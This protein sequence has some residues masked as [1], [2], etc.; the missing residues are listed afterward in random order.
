[1]VVLGVLF[2]GL[3]FVTGDDF[4]DFIEK[5]NSLIVLEGPVPGSIEEDLPDNLEPE[6]ANMYAFEGGITGTAKDTADDF[7]EAN[8]R[9]FKPDKFEIPTGA[10]PSP[11]FGARPFSQKLLRLEEFGNR[12]LPDPSD[13]VAGDSFPP[14]LDA[15]S[16]PDS[17]SLDNFLDQGLYPFPQREANVADFNPWQPEIEEFLDRPLDDPPV[18]GRPP[19]PDWSHQRWAEFYPEVYVKTAQRGARTNRGYRDSGQLH[20][21]SLGEFAPGG[22][23]HNTLGNAVSDPDFEGTTRGI[24]VKFHPNMPEQHPNSLWT[25]DGTF[26]PK[27]LMVR[28]GEPILFRHYNALPIDPAANM[29]F[30]LHTITT[31]EHNGH[32]PAESDGFIQAFFFPGQFYDYRWPLC[33]AGHDSINVDA[34]DDRAGAPDGNG[35]INRIPG[36]YRETMSTH[37]FHDHMM[38]FTAPNVYKG[39][40]AAMNYYSSLDRGN[41]GLEDGV[42]LRLPSGTAL[43]WGNRDYDVN[44]L[45]SDKAWDSDGQLFF[46]IFNMDGFLGDR[47]LTNWLWNPYFDV[48]ARRYRFRLLNGA[49]ARYF[50]LALVREYNGSG[51]R[52]RGPSGSRKT[53]DRVPFHMIANDG[54][55]MEHSVLFS[56]GLTPTLSIGERYDIIV[57]FSQFEPGTKLHLVNVLEHRNGKRPHEVVFLGEVLSGEYRI[58]QWPNE[59]RKG[60]PAVGKI[61][62]FRVH[63]YTGTDLSMDPAD[64][65]SVLPDGQKGRK[66]IPL[67]TFTE[68]E[69]DNA[70]HRT[71]EFGK[72]SGT[73]SDPWTIKTDGGRGLLSDPR[74]VSAAPSLGG[75]EIWHLKNGGGGWS[76][77]IHVHFEEGVILERG[78]EPP[79]EWEKWARKDMFRVGRMGDSGDSVVVAFRFR[80]FL[81]TYMEHCH[82]TQ[83]EDHAMLLRFDSENPGQ[84]RVMPTPMPTWDGVGYV[85]SFA[86]PT[87]RAGDLEATGEHVFV[88]G[89]VNNDLTLDVADPV[90]LLLFLFQLGEAPKCLAAADCNDDELIDIVDP[91]FEL[92]ALF[93]GGSSIPAPWPD[94]GFDPTP[95]IGCDLSVAQNPNDNAGLGD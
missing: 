53:Y 38:D 14:P 68:E 52:M 75:V 47:V 58:D 45:I 57:D 22:L 30:G 51:G 85:P 46:N 89:N 3:P 12:E 56:N 74:R 60:D 40:I 91:V 16:G 28:V 71:F 65:V 6:E 15:Q 62:E 7:N 13:V 63:E 92:L 20:E 61:M 66:M 29:G 31:H 72:S 84:M 93:G 18:E 25:F 17:E 90:F 79:P 83:H 77:P 2:V 50:R 21:Y 27:L 36:D 64:F 81:G 49:V 87:F 69:L 5:L 70:R 55:I 34:T 23:Y 37:W 94:P 82:N 19:G 80:E 67:P 59:W 4:D 48:R 10:V 11:L 26:P 73:D 24:S 44:L 43:D 9:G 1:M 54:N 78:G 42:N 41:E 33:L 95:G 39:N 88:R 76:H 35:G 8:L 86:L 32:T